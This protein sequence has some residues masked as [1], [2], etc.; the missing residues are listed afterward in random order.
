LWAERLRARAVVIGG[1]EELSVLSLLDVLQ[2]Y[3]MREAGR[4]EFSRAS[5]LA[6][7]YDVAK[8]A[9]AAARAKNAGRS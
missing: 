1:S 2:K 9:I 3:G 6:R 4:F 7:E 8:A 5:K